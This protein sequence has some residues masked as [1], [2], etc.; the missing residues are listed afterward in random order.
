MFLYMIILSYVKHTARVTP[1]NLLWFSI[2]FLFLFLFYF[3][4]FFFNDQPQN[5]QQY[6]LIFTQNGSFTSPW[7]TE[8]LY[9]QK[10]RSKFSLFESRACRPGRSIILWVRPS[11]HVQRSAMKAIGSSLGLLQKRPKIRQCRVKMVLPRPYN[12]MHDHYIAWQLQ[13]RSTWYREQSPTH[14]QYAWLLARH[15]VVNS[16]I[17]V[18]TRSIALPTYKPKNWSGLRWPRHVHYMHSGAPTHE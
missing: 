18:S 4:F 16:P 9:C 3:F 15:Y 12:S 17:T 1:R 11:G 13:A 2:F 7:P 10:Q 8:S 5:W 14:I 6:I